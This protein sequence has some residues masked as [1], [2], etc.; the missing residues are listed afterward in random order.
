MLVAFNLNQNRA[1]AFD[2][3]SQSSTGLE[4]T[5]RESRFAIHLG[6]FSENFLLLFMKLANKFLIAHRSFNIVVE[7]CFT[8][9]L[10]STTKSLD[11][12]TKMFCYLTLTGKILF[13]A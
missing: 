4:L 9:I 1:I 7:F 5:H 3:H 2:T 10:F 13:H 8:L 12:L 6:Y 11:L